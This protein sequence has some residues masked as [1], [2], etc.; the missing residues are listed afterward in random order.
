LLDGV[1][2]LINYRISVDQNTFFLF[3]K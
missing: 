2:L 1:I 3:I